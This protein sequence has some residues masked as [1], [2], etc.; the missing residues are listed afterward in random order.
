MLV[1]ASFSCQSGTNSGTVSWRLLF[2]ET[3]RCV[4]VD[5]G[6]Q[7]VQLKFIYQTRRRHIE[8]GC[9]IH[10]QMSAR[11]PPHNTQS[12]PCA[13]LDRSL[14]IQ[15]VEASRFRDMRHMK[16]V[17]LSALRTGRLYPIRKYCW[18]S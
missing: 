3:W 8:G 9:S 1:P 7:E 18:Y 11:Q 5:G 2:C 17:N 12:D 10:C 14:R 16:V 13:S 6:R 4:L 15:E